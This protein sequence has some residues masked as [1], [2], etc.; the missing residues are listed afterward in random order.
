MLIIKFVDGGKNRRNGRIA[1]GTTF[2]ARNPLR[3]P[4][5]NRLLSESVATSGSVIASKNLETPSAMPTS[6]MARKT[7]SH[8]MNF[9]KLIPSNGM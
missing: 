5:F 8:C 7:V 9:G 3:L 1:N 4:N 2:I 6:V